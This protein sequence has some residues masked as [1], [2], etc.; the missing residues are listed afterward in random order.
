MKIFLNVWVA[1]ITTSSCVVHFEIIQSYV[2]K[3]S[4]KPTTIIGCFD[5]KTHI[6]FLKIFM[7]S[8][9]Y[10]QIMRLNQKNI[11]NNLINK[12]SYQAEM[13]VDG[14]CL[15]STNFLLQVRF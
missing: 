15:K 1:I 12:N 13:I 14:D 5:Q 9:T 3:H 8:T 6:Y 4:A 2:K 10:V 11:Y 7:F